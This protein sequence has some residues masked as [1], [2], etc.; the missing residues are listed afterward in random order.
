M[1]ETNLTNIAIGPGC[2]LP[3]TNRESTGHSA[4]WCFGPAPPPKRI[5]RNLDPKQTKSSNS[6]FQFWFDISLPLLPIIM[7]QW[8]KSSPYMKGNDHNWRQPI[9]HWTMM[10]GGRVNRGVYLYQPM[11]PWGPLWTFLLPGL[12]RW[13]VD[14]LRWE[15]WYLNKA[16][17]LGPLDDDN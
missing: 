10:M 16:G 1:E 6:C 5:Q 4:S 13:M 2:Y 14:G 8:K 17:G 15:A 9:F 11:L 3:E 7:V 12:R